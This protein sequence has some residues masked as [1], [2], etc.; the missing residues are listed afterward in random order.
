[1]LYIEMASQ[2]QPFQNSFWI[3]VCAYVFIPVVSPY[4]LGYS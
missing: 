4:T 3:I 1:M 2:E